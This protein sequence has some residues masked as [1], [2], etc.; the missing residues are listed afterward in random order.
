[1]GGELGFAAGAAH[2]V[3]RLDEK[4]GGLVV[5]AGA[6]IG[7]GEFE[8]F[9]EAIGLLLEVS[10]EDVAGA[11][12]PAGAQQGLT[13][14]REERS[15]VIF[16]RE[17]IEQSDGAFGV[18][19]AEFRFGEE[20]SAAAIFG[21]ELVGVAE[22]FEGFVEAADGLGELAGAKIAARG[23]VGVA[24]LLGKLGER[25]VT[26]GIFRV[27]HSETFVTG[28]RFDFALLL[29]VETGGGAELFDGLAGAVELLEEHAVAH[30]AIGR[31]GEGAEKA[32]EDG[33]GFG[34]VAGVDEPVKLHAVVLGGLGGFVE[35]CIDVGERLKRLLMGRHLFDD[36]LIFGNSLA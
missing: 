17:G 19:L 8:E 13:E 34:G 29:E 35:A 24:E 31:L 30:Q 21:R 7:G 26:S 4:S 18:A 6:E 2:P 3:F 22:I 33:G 28:E 12:E 16:R 25:D 11:V 27:E 23:E 9:A 14:E 32:R 15:V 10:L 1:M 20:E 5:E 36:G